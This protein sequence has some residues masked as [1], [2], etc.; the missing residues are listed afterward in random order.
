M[1][2][3]AA[4]AGLQC[5]G[6]GH[7]VAIGPVYKGCPRCGHVLITQ[8]E[9]LEVGLPV[10]AAAEAVAGRVPASPADLGQG[11]TP[12]LRADDPDGTVWLKCETANPTLSHKDRMQS[13]VSAMSRKLGHPGLVTTSTGNNGVAAAAFARRAG[14]KCL[15]IAHPGMPA[16]CIWAISAL[17]AS[18]IT[19]SPL[20]TER[21]LIG[22]LV[23]RG[24]APVT[25]ADP[26]C[27]SGWANPYIVDGY[28][29]IGAEICAQLGRIPQVVALPVAGGDTFAGVWYGLQEVASTVGAAPP[30]MLAVQPEG[31]AWMARAQ[32][33]GED[34]S[35]L[36][37]PSTAALSV[38]SELAGRHAVRSLITSGG[39]A[40]SVP[41]ADMLA[42]TDR[43][44]GLGLLV[45]A[46]S[47]LPS[48]GIRL[49]RAAGNIKANET[50]VAVVTSSAFKWPTN[51]ETLPREP[52][53]RDRETLLEFVA[54][55]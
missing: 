3:H 24:W 48:A 9:A 12:L 4:P 43:L 8:Y 15:V 2:A 44:A 32:R 20:A 30:R 1:R 28:R 14:L 13:V 52:S 17:G 36:A 42:E 5:L 46:T 38:L 41:E 25:S 18:I 10:A 21:E 39:L 54:G 35:P 50:C 33:D 26:R 53:I 55:L 51:G 27:G 23:A 49:A 7:C 45:E 22:T 31:A 19:A 37:A 47:A 6:C 34:A 29:S 11:S 40:I 16:N